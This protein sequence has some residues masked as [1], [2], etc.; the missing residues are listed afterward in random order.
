MHWLICKEKYYELYKF[1]LRKINKNEDFYNH[2]RNGI[3]V[4]HFC[5]KETPKSSGEFYQTLKE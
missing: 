2:Q 4:K 3:S 1:V 5:T